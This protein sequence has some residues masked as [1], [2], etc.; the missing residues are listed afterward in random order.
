MSTT[1]SCV[2]CLEHATQVLIINYESRAISAD[3]I[4]DVIT[5]LYYQRTLYPVYLCV[6]SATLRG[7]HMLTVHLQCL[8]LKLLRESAAVHPWPVCG[9]WPR[10]L[11]LFLICQLCQSVIPQANDFPCHIMNPSLTYVSPVYDP[12]SYPPRFNKY[13]LKHLQLIT[14]PAQAL[15]R[16][17][18]RAD[19]TLSIHIAYKY[20][21]LLYTSPSPRD[22]QKSRMPSSA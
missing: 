9:G 3:T 20:A 15:V 13:I 5:G 2:P 17:R 4:R 7:D 1:T 21:C 6:K 12:F 19:S 10:H 22:R 11:P 14:R 16:G 8:P 18:G